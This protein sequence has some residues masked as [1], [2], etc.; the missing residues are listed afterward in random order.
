MI[1]PRLFLCGDIQVPDCED[2]CKNRVVVKLS[3]SGPNQNV[4]LVIEDLAKKF[5]EDLQPRLADLIEI[6]A[7]V[8]AAD[9]A[10]PRSGA[11][12]DS[13]G[14]EPWQRDFSFVIPVVDP[15]FWAK[16]LFLES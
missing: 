3:T 15:D 5:K 2:R 4:N 9:C 10:T 13:G 7:Y 6:A 1:R 8:Y 12:A 11:W 14:T 16:T